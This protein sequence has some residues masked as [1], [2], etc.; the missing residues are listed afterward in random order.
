MSTRVFRGLKLVHMPRISSLLPTRHPAL[1]TA[2]D[3]RDSLP[4]VNGKTEVLQALMIS[5]RKSVRRFGAAAVGALVL[6]FLA[7]S[8]WLGSLIWTLAAIVGALALFVVVTV[9]V[10]ERSIAGV[11]A[12]APDVVWIHGGTLA[13]HLGDPLLTGPKTPPAWTFSTITLHVR[14][15]ESHAFL[16]PAVDA[17]S[18]LERMLRAFPAA[19][20]GYSDA[21]LAQFVR[22]PNSLERRGP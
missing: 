7:M 20:F 9:L 17:S 8:W 11:P 1:L 6:A 10:R 2:Y 22:D 16:V 14:S 13:T 15:G 3:S 12:L 18:L 19:S 5:A 4:A 21:L